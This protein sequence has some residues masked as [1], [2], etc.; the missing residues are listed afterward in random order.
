M[1]ILTENLK[2]SFNMND[3]EHRSLYEKLNE[4]IESYSS[5]GFFEKNEGL[6][7]LNF[8]SDYIVVNPTWEGIYLTNRRKDSVFM[9]KNKKDIMASYPY[10]KLEKF[11]VDNPR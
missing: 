4:F 9:Y 10:I 3:Q 7:Q 2:A 6:Y 8:A 5:H 1:I 11:L